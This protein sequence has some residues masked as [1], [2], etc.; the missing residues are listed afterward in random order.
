MSL[1]ERRKIKVTC[2]RSQSQNRRPRT[3]PRPVTPKPGHLPSNC[4]GWGDADANKLHSHSSNIVSALISSVARFPFY[5]W[6][7]Q[8][9]GKD[10]DGASLEEMKQAQE[11]GQGQGEGRGNKVDDYK[12]GRYAHTLTRKLLSL[13]WVTMTTESCSF[14]SKWT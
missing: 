14:S 9:P 3:V 10:K 12:G 11:A 1:L 8:G 5:R 2:P 4:N 6:G 7:N 13:S